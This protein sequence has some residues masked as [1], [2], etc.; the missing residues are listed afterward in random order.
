M[1]QRTPTWGSGCRFPP[2]QGCAAERTYPA[3]E[4]SGSG[5]EELPCVRGKEQRLHFARAA[6]VQGKRIPSKVVGT[7]RWGQKADKLKLQS[8]TTGQS[9]HTDQNLV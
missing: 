4:V 1:A 6:H 2:K 9:D 3:P 7:E 8:Q 5:Q